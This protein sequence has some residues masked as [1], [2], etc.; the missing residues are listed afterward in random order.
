MKMAIIGAQ[1]HYGFALEALQL[2]PE[3]HLEGVSRSRPG[4]EL[5][6]VATGA[7]KYGAPVFEDYRVMLDAVQPDVAVVNPYFCDTADVSMECLKRGIH[8]FSEK[9]LATRLDRLDAL[10]ETWRASGRALAGMFNL[11]YCG[12]FLTVKQAVAQ[13]LIG[14]VRAASGRKSYKMGTRGPVY[15]RRETFGGILPWVA[16]HALDWVL[17]I[18]GPVQWI[19]GTQDNRLNRGNGDMDTAGAILLKTENGVIGTVTADFYRPAGSARH[20]DDRLMVTGTEGM[21]EAL[22]GRV[23]LEND[24]PRRE[25]PLVPG[26]QC[27]MEMLKAIGTDDAR[28]MGLSALRVTRAALQAR[29]GVYGR[30]DL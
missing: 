23:F 27:F 14:T 3:L 30:N 29:D 2:D 19:A 16:I 15:Q 7:Q 5:G 12:W 9:P 1:G 26:R 28:E 24:Q 18:G 20:D 10:E 22:N 8:V 21:L 17:E 4:E 25:L 13:G 11:R 6:G